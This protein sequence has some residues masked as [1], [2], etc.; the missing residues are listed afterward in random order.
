MAS[1]PLPVLPEVP[2]PRVG[3]VWATL[4]NAKGRKITVRLPGHVLWPPSYLTVGGNVYTFENWD[5]PADA[6]ARIDATYT[7][8]D[9]TKVVDITDLINAAQQEKAA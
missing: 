6:N 3:N 1:N 8:T 5:V 2:Q 7:P 4:T 9:A